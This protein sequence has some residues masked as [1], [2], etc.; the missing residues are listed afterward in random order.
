MQSG[1]LK[2]TDNKPVL[3]LPC[4]GPLNFYQFLKS[5]VKI[6]CRIYCSENLENSEEPVVTRMAQALTDK[7]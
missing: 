2:E 1:K 6:R 4:S 7:T 5:L 3:T